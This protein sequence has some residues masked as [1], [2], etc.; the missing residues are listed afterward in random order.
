MDDQIFHLSTDRWKHAHTH[1]LHN[2]IF[3][4]F[5]KS[6]IFLN[7]FV[8]IIFAFLQNMEVIGIRNFA[9]V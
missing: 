5:E 9:N 8:D 6:A 4:Y 1:H 3:L 2:H 7:S